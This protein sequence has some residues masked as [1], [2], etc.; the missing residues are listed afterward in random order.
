MRKIS[1]NIEIGYFF[2]SR[3]FFHLSS[4]LNTSCLSV[5]N[6]SNH[7]KCFLLGN[8]KCRTQPTLINLHSNDNSQEFYYNPFEVKLDRCAGS[9]N[10]LNDLSK[11]VCI[12]N[13]RK[14]LNL[15]IFNMITG[16][17]ELKTLAKHI[18]C[19]CKCKFDDTKWKSNQWWNNDKCWCECK[20]HHICEKD[21]VW[22]PAICNCGNGKHLASIM[23]DSVITR[24]EVTKSCDEGAETKSNDETKTIPTNFNEKNITCKAQ[25]FYLTFY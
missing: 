16:I 2:K 12:Q 7:T 24:D 17:N 20:K 6:G 13:K 14:N 18:S 9:R 22:N 19:E 23:D 25:N 3:A 10:T 8:P 4:N 15:S 1:E 11:K 5:V 21:Y